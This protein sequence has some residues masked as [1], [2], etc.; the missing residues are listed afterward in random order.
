MSGFYHSNLSQGQQTISK[1]SKRESSDEDES[2]NEHDLASEREVD[3]QGS[4]SVSLHQ[5]E[6]RMLMTCQ[7]TKIEDVFINLK[8]N[9]L[10]QMLKKKTK[11]TWTNL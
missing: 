10:S 7:T 8:D 1:P 6:E 11:K 4:K 9:C 5:L 2:A 3:R